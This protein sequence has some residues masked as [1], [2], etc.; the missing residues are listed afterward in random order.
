M[1]AASVR[2]LRAALLSFRSRN[3]HFGT[4]RHRSW[5]DG[6]DNQPGRGH[7]PNVECPADYPCG[8]DCD[9]A[10]KQR[11]WGAPCSAKCRAAQQALAVTQWADAPEPEQMGLF[12]ASA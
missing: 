5:V 1:S 9:V 11:G 10:A 3:G 12:E 2:Q 8:G 6:Y 7:V 4:C